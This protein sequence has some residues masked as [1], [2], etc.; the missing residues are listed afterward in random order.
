[1]KKL[2]TLSTLAS[3]SFA[4]CG[5]DTVSGWIE[6]DHVCDASCQPICQYE[7]N[8]SGKK[9]EEDWNNFKAYKPFVYK[10]S[11]N[12]FLDTQ[13]QIYAKLSNQLYSEVITPYLEADQDGVIQTYRQFKDTIATEMKLKNISRKEATEIVAAKIKQENPANYEK[14]IKSY[15]TLDNREFTNQLIKFVSAIKPELVQLTTNLISGN[16]NVG[17]VELAWA[18][19]QLVPEINR[20]IDACSFLL[21]T[22]DDQDGSAAEIETFFNELNTTGGNAVKAETPAEKETSSTEKK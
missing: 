2:L 19:Y 9:T 17:Y 20:A 7:F 15:K 6:P 13:V 14:I 12:Q 10:P 22:L 16:Q 21:E 18:T 3:I 8:K 11:G 5:C 1:M 4:L